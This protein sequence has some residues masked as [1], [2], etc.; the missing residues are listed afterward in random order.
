M[1]QTLRYL[2]PLAVLLT[3][4][5]VGCSQFDKTALC[6][7][8]ED[9]LQPVY[10]QERATV[11]A[12]D[13]IEVKFLNHPDMNTRTFVELDG[14]IFMPLMG[15]LTVADKTTR[16]I[17]AEMMAFY[18]QE[19]R[20]LDITIATEKP[21]A[22]VFVTGEV[23]AGGPLPF[24]TNMTMAQA[25]AAAAPNLVK[26]DIRSAILVR[27]SESEP[28]SYTSYLVNGDFAQGEARNIYLSPGDVVVVPRKGIAMAGDW[29]QMYVR[30]IIPPQ[31]S[32]NYGLLHEVHR[33]NV[34]GGT[35]VG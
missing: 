4:W 22:M 11:A 34:Y 17:H 5:L 26:G 2:L 27:K 25:L 1:K 9:M 10:P 15:N 33:K 18:Q 32:V 28:D 13:I 30:D 23:M 19:L 14:T 21:D 7:V 29:V 12:G 3:V 31:M 16:E 20:A 35:A 6:E 8:T 24:R